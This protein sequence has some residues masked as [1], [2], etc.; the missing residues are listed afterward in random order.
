M[1]VILKIFN[2]MHGDAMLFRPD[3]V[4]KNVPLLIDTGAKKYNIYQK[5]SNEQFDIMITHSDNDHMGGLAD[6]LNNK[7]KEC[8]N[9][10]LPLYLP[11]IYT[12]FSKLMN[13]GSANRLNIQNAQNIIT[14]FQQKVI[15][16]YDGWHTSKRKNCTCNLA[17]CSHS[18]I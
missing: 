2:V 8:Q 4:F 5:I 15:F 9:I 16:V 13:I 12:I 14:M 18:R 10:Y 3:C 6:F 17:Q 7:S 1:A 11:E